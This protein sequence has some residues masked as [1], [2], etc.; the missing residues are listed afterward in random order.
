MKHPSLQVRYNP[1]PRLYQ[2]ATLSTLLFYGI[3]WLDFEISIS[4]VL[5]LVGTSLLTQLVCTWVWELPKYDPKS[6]LISSLSLCLLLRTND[7]E[8]AILSAI[9]TI[10]SKFIFRFNGKHFFNPTNFGIIAVILFTG[11]VWIS[12]GQWGN[13]ALFGFL[14]A[15]LGGVVVN[16]ASRSDVTYAFLVF[17][18]AILFGRAVWLGQPFSIPLH[19]V[20][21]GGFLLFTFFMISDPKPTPNS[22]AGR[23]LFAFLVAAG[24]G[25]V[26]FV[27]FRPNGLFWSLALFSMTTPIIDWLLPG[28]KYEW[29]QHRERRQTL[30]QLIEERR[31][32]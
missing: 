29:M 4:R 15:C 22:R 5:V 7:T 28:T 26:H 24:A 19:M 1:D 25:F 8:M 17:Y 18:L 12:P 9:I 10:A 16:H 21:N 14:M 13:A 3:G 23:I 27:L 30:N 6:A 31:F 20:Q 32:T 2:V 11:E